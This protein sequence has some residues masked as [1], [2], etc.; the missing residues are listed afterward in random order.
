MQ[1]RDSWLL[2]RG[3]ARSASGPLKGPRPV[4]ATGRADLGPRQFYAGKDLRAGNR[5]LFASQGAVPVS[6]DQQTDLNR[7]PAGGTHTAVRQAGASSS[8][9]LKPGASLA[10]NKKGAFGE[11][12]AAKR[13]KRGL[14]GWNI[15]R[16]ALVLKTEPFLLT[17]P[18]YPFCCKLVTRAPVSD[19]G[20]FLCGRR[21]A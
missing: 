20:L 11:R 21:A 13:S 2:S 5:L 7:L 14:L 4:I 18:F 1:L 9:R 3:A 12:S 10:T 16:R 15:M 19:R 8:P 6:K 17:F